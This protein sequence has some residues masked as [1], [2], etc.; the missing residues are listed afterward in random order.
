MRYLGRMAITAAAF[1]SDASLRIEFVSDWA[2]KYH[3]AYIGRRLAGETSTPTERAI[4]LV[5]PPA[6]V[7]EWITLVAVDADELGIDIGSQ[8]GQ[9]PYNRVAIEWTT[10]GWDDAATI[11]IASGLAPG[12]AVVASNVIARTLFDTNRRY[13]LMTPSLSGP[14]R[15]SWNFEV[16]GR[17][18]VPPVGNRGTAAAIS[19]SVLSPPQDIALR[20]VTAPR[21]TARV[22]SQ[23]LILEWTNGN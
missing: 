9:R 7:P 15:R 11:E 12:G 3:Q 8:L 17:D 13:S 6:D 19:A 22:E 1:I 23:N 20:S 14:G 5:A 16:A 18:A 21:F 10:S 2:G 4:T